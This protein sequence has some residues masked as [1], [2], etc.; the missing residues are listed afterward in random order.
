[1]KELSE[2]EEKKLIKKCIKHNIRAQEKFYRLYAKKMYGLCKGYSNTVEEAND[3]MQEAF[4]K[5]FKNMKQYNEKGDVGAWV[6]RIFINTAIDYYR[7]SKRTVDIIDIDTNINEE[8]FVSED[9]LKQ[10]DYD[11]FIELMRLLPE[12][13]RI[14]FNL[15]NLEGYSH[16][17]IAVKL[18]ISESTSKSQ[19]HRA[20]QLLKLAISKQDF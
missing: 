1:M 17:E 15:F 4:I 11:K 18:G 12:K 16:K 2:I 5:V 6:R 8:I 9:S 10:I 19:Y 7:K 14:I 20:K 3:I 13:A